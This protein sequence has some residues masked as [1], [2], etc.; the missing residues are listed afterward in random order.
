M[1]RT[2]E[3]VAQTGAEIK[4]GGAARS[5]FEVIEADVQFYA[6][7]TVSEWTPAERKA[8]YGR[9]PQGEGVEGTVYILHFDAPISDR[10]T[11]QH[12]IGWASDLEARIELH[13]KGR[14]ARLTQVAA[15]RGIA[16]SVV[17]TFPG[18]RADERRLKN[19]KATTALCPICK[20]LRRE[21]QNAAR[22]A[23]RAA[24]RA[25]KAEQ[26]I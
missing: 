12:Y 13:R 21:R 14:G 2:N 17:A 4:T 1:Q 15:Q 26:V 22:R 9:E 20:A 24:Q 3:M 25:A 19:Q 23:Q 18:T 11:T 16:F 7:R 8:F 5:P 6:P 10:H